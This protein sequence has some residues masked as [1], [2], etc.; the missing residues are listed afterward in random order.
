MCSW[1]EPGGWK[2]RHCNICGFGHP[3]YVSISI[4]TDADDSDYPYTTTDLCRECW[5]ALGIGAALA[6]NA[7]LREAAG[8]R[9][10]LG[11]GPF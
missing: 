6:H 3:A 11:V 5:V 2:N 8:T 10:G 9:P 4:A 1:C 7:A